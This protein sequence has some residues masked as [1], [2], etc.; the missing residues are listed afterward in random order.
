MSP[1]NF[2]SKT[3]FTRFFFSHLFQLNLQ[4]KN[5]VIEHSGKDC[6]QAGIFGDT[7]DFLF[8]Y[9]VCQT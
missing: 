7:L 2:N 5:E 3:N 6:L 4:L 9:V 8:P 1:L